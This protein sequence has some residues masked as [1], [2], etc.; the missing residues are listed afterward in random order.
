MPLT[1]DSY[2]ALLLEACATFDM[3]CELPGKQKRAVY[4]MA[5]SGN[6]LDEPCDPVDDE[7]YTAYSV[8][9]TILEIMANAVDSNQF[10]GKSGNRSQ[11]SGRI[12]YS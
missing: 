10:S 5:I 7:G 6:N 1:Y 8:D 12:P 3:R 4:T 2:R 11:G 9:T